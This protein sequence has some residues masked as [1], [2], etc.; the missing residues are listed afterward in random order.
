MAGMPLNHQRSGHSLVRELCAAIRRLGSEANNG[1][2]LPDQHWRVVKLDIRLSRAWL[3]NN[4]RIV[5]FR[6]HAGLSKLTYCIMFF[7]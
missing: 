4:N 2:E 3:Y 5:P 6:L 1:S 7:P